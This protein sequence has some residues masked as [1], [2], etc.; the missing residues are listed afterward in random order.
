MQKSGV[1]S[2]FPVPDSGKCDENAEIRGQS[3]TFPVPNSGNATKLRT[4]AIAVPIPP[5]C[6]TTKQW[7]GKSYSN[8]SDHFYPPKYTHAHRSMKELE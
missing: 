7:S 5:A 6:A 2:A 3:C 4:F 8:P 1:D